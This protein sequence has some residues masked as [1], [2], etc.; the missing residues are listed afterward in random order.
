M[1]INQQFEI[2]N[3]KVSRSGFT[4][5][6]L[7]VVIAIIGLLTA[8]LLPAV[9]SARE[10]GRRL[11][12]TNHLKQIGL[13]CVN[14]T[15]V[16]KHFPTDG[17]GYSWVGDPDRGF[18][19]RQPG[20]WLYNI[21]PYIEEEILWQLGTGMPPMSPERMAANSQRV[22]TIV[23]VFVCPTRRT[24]DLWPAGGA[25]KYAN[26]VY[27]A[28]R[29]DYAIN[30]GDT[31]T[32]VYNGVGPPDLPSADTATWTAEFDYIAKYATG[33]SYT[34]SHVRIPKV[35][36]GFTKT[37]LI[38][39]K[40]LNPLTYLTGSSAD[41]ET[42]FMGSNGD[43]E[44]WTSWSSGGGYLPPKQDTPGDDDWWSFGSAHIGAFNMVF[45][46]GSVHAISYEIDPEIHRRLGNRAD[47]KLI[48]DSLF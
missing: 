27:K 45:C 4:L 39:E 16:H 38:G 2:K 31:F 12:C 42:I 48:D 30:G 41:S 32:C 21:L 37:Y 20:G 28:F 24:P 44:H 18:N 5:V 35:T 36:D 26:P 13:A 46:D 22:T 23:P 33:I 19:R 3:P 25:I 1:K 40:H 9:Q 47:G 7:L 6:E 8:L 29:S 34:A 11:Q 14:H 15:E 17:W 43:I 10:S